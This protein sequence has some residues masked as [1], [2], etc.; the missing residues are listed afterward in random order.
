MVK[1]ALIHAAFT[2]SSS[3]SLQFN[4]RPSLYIYMQGETPPCIQVD[5]TAGV[6]VQCCSGIKPGTKPSFLESQEA[7]QQSQNVWGGSLFL[8]FSLT[9]RAKVSAPAHLIQKP[10]CQAG[11]L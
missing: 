2:S 11:A 10:K 1:G 9:R 5:K 8:L 7:Q 6:G 3:C 4:W